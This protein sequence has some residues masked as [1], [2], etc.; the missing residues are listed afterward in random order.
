[1]DGGGVATG[2]EIE[3]GVGGGGAVED[4]GEDVAGGGV[5]GVEGREGEAV[6]ALG[7]DGELAEGDG[8]WFA[9]AGDG[10]VEVLIAEGETEFGG[11]VFGGFDDE[12]GGDVAGLEELAEPE[13][14]LGGV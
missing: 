6:V 7:G 14:V 10:G 3:V 13:R 11:G 2:F 5:L 1:M 12:T 9:G 4:E 8:D